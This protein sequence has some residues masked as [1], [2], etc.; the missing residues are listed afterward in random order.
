MGLSGQIHT[1]SLRVNEGDVPIVAHLLRIDPLVDDGLVVDR[2]DLEFEDPRDDLRLPQSSVSG[3]CRY[4]SV[5]PPGPAAGRFDYDSPSMQGILG[6]VDGI[7]ITDNNETDVVTDVQD[8]V[9]TEV[10]V[11]QSFGYVGSAE[12]RELDE[13][14][15]RGVPIPRNKPTAL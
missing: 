2:I 15:S 13:L 12:I 4:F 6:H 10:A 3:I 11:G 5:A 9:D 7:E 14:L 8:I 1:L